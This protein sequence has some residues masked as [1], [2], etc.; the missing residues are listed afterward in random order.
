MLLVTSEDHLAR[1]MAVGQ[2][3]AGSRGIHLTGVPVA[4]SPDC[5]EE[6]RLKQIS[7]WLRA[8]AWVIT[9]R[10]LRDAA[11]LGPEVR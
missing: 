11:N 3:V 5:E 8:M 1:S 6:G 4:C 9:G 2:V 7:D 10:D